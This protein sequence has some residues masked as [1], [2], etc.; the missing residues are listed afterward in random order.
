VTDPVKRPWAARTP[1]SLL[2]E[3]ED[4]VAAYHRDVDGK[5]FIPTI[6]HPKLTEADLLLQAALVRTLRDAG[7]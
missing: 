2:K 5:M 3:A 1:E 7:R 4:L 6:T